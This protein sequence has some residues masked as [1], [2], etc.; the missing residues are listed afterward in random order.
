MGNMVSLFSNHSWLQF[1][2]YIVCLHKLVR[3]RSLPRR[4]WSV[5]FVVEYRNG[6][7]AMDF[8]LKFLHLS[9]SLS[10]RNPREW[11]TCVYSILHYPSGSNAYILFSSPL[12]P[13]VAGTWFEWCRTVPCINGAYHFVPRVEFIFGKDCP[14]FK[15]PR[16][17]HCNPR[18]LVIILLFEMFTVV[19]LMQTNSQ[20]G[21]VVKTKP[22]QVCI[23]A[24]TIEG[25]RTACEGWKS[26]ARAWLGTLPSAQYVPSP[27]CRAFS[28]NESRSLQTIVTFGHRRCTWER[29]S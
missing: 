8:V 20:Q 22:Q 16:V 4:L 3:I 5:T 19:G 11:M 21:K 18:E 23:I 9:I 24:Y 26:R 1:P 17:D 25:C 29:K 13:R 27:L 14:P 10:Y 12:I 7:P 2:K 28:R 6:T 15:T